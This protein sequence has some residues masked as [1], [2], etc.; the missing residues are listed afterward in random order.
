MNTM[1]D[2][3][4]SGHLTFTSGWEWGYWLVDWS[5][6]RWSW[7]IWDNGRERATSPLSRLGELFPDPQMRSLWQEALALQNLFLKD[8][9]LMRYMAA[10]TP[11]SELPRPFNEAFQ[12]EPEISNAGLLH[13]AGQQQADAVLRGPVSNLELYAVRM[14]RLVRR[15]DQRGEYLRR[16]GTLNGINIKLAA[17]LSRGLQ[18]TALRARQRALT[19]RA[20]LA[21]RGAHDDGISRA[22]ASDP[23]LEKARQ[24]RR[25]AWRLV[26]QQEN[27][28][29]YPIDQVARRRPSR[30]AYPFGY[31]YPASNLY[32]WEREEEQV[33][34]ERFDALFMNLWDVCRTLGLESLFFKR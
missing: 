26:V 8:R 20:L 31:L 25:E 1:A 17:E 27:F 14:G 33:R 2:I 10:L 23:L 4:V 6:A 12:P 18:V 19:L 16:Q 13:D 5:I 29:R 21:R 30:T 15:L 22:A 7:R 3:G 24:V 28:Y 32:F 34:A 11:F 9:E